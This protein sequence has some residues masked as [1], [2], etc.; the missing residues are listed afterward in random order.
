[1]AAIF[2]LKLKGCFNSLDLVCPLSDKSKR[3]QKTNE[4]K[5]IKTE[6]EKET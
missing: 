3:K 6:E 5:Q 1:M 4:E 2:F